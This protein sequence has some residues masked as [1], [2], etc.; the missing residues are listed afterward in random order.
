MP[1][2]LVC[3]R[4]APRRLELAKGQRR[5]TTGEDDRLPFGHVQARSSGDDLSRI[6]VSSW[7]Q[8]QYLMAMQRPKSPEPERHS[9][10]K[11]ARA[12]LARVQAPADYVPVPLE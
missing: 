3:G 2:R 11:Y 10:K 7:S 9:K 5:S 4:A 6:V 12:G 8:G 1:L